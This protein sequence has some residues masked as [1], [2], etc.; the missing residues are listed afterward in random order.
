MHI[1]FLRKKII[2]ISFILLIP[3]ILT[4]RHSLSTITQE[5]TDLSTLEK[6]EKFFTSRDR[7]EELL[8]SRSGIEYLLNKREN[9]SNKFDAHLLWKSGEISQS[10]PLYQS[11]LSEYTNIINDPNS[12]KEEI[13]DA[14]EQAAKINIKLGNFDEAIQIC[15]RG[16]GVFPRNSSI[17]SI[18]AE[19]H[20]LRAVAYQCEREYDLSI[21]NLQNILTIE[22]LPPDWYAFAKSYLAHLYLKEGKDD[23]AIDY[24]QSIIQNHPKLDNWQAL[25]HY[26]L[27]DYY[28]N[29]RDYLNAREELKTIITRHPNSDWTKPAKDKLRNLE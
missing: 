21:E 16:L 8:I 5:K 20:Y 14:L 28:I 7:A 27:A 25:A 4:I 9:S 6:I 15:Q 22:N 11:S 26:E 2:L 3:L 23:I 17:L 12:T 24:F 10:T 19:V 29:K 1:R 13:R 18:I